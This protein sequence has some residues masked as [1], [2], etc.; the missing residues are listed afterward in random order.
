MT[1]RSSPT[2]FLLFHRSK[3]DGGSSIRSRDSHE[4][5]EITR[6]ILDRLVPAPE[7]DNYPVFSRIMVLPF[8]LR[9]PSFI[10]IASPGPILSF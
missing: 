4:Y 6:R 9:L 7:D 1:D 5:R 2:R 8:L 3:N 10:P